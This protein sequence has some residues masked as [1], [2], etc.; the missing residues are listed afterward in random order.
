MAADQIRVRV[1]GKGPLKKYVAEEEAV[2]PRGS[3]MSEL[4]GRYHIPIGHPV[5][6]MKDGK[7]LS[8]AMKLHDGDHI[9]MISMI[10]GG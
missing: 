2:V 4:V 7:R 5:I 1:S 8:P 10:S 9:V 6:C 3:T